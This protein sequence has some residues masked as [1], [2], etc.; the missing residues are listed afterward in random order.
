MVIRESGDTQVDVER[1]PS[2]E[3]DNYSKMVVA[4]IVTESK[5][6]LLE[7]GRIIWMGNLQRI[8]FA[9]AV[10]TSF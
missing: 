10:E 9:V 7:D 3:E 6:T 4:A 5:E 2:K 1:Q 8:V